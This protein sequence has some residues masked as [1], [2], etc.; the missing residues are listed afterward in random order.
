MKITNRLI[1]VPVLIIVGIVM[2]FVGKIFL[3]AFFDVV[4]F[5]GKLI[6]IIPY[7]IFFMLRYFGVFAAAALIFLAAAGYISKRRKRNG[8]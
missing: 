3:S 7:I 5:S 8:R 1:W 6:F 4:S 2:H